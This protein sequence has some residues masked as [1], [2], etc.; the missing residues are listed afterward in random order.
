MRWV[1]AHHCLYPV[2]EE[3]SVELALRIDSIA[4][5]TAAAMQ[6][7][8]RP[9]ATN[10][11]DKNHT[12]VWEGGLFFL[13]DHTQACSTAERRH[14]RFALVS[15]ILRAEAPEAYAR[16]YGAA[17]WAASSWGGAARMVDEDY[18]IMKFNEQYGTS[19]TVCPD[20]QELRAFAAQLN[21]M[22]SSTDLQGCARM[23]NPQRILKRLV[24]HLRYRTRMDEAGMDTDD[25]VCTH[26]GMYVCTH[27]RIHA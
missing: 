15:C 3:A 1:E 21:R 16:C 4:A 2:P 8:L 17:P 24:A 14:R 10:L 9:A 12:H 7:H 19:H 5:D 18:V 27:V 6:V 23:R 25:S 20:L 11:R 26:V 13:T 22:Q